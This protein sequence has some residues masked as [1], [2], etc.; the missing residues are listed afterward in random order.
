MLTSAE[1]TGSYRQRMPGCRVASD[2]I[3][4]TPGTEPLHYTDPP[5]GLEMIA[6]VT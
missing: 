4:T 6:V 3:V 1:E 2:I 5:P